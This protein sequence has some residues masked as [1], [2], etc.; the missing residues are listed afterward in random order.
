MPSVPKELGSANAFYAYLGV[1]AKERPFLEKYAF[2]RY[3]QA[4]IPKRRGGIRLLLVP[5]RRLK[6]LQRQTLKLL[7]QLHSPRMHA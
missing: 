1:G 5:E 4:S 7:S 2:Y 3:T 6:F